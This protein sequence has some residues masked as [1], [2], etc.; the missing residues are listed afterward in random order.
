MSEELRLHEGRSRSLAQ[1]LEE[2]L[3][4]WAERTEI[5]VEI[6]ALPAHDVPPSTAR[7]VLATLGEALANVESHSGA[8]V[9]SVA[10]TLGPSGLRMTVS[11]NGVGFIGPL[12]GR[13][14]TAMRTHFDQVGGTLSIN[15]VLGEG[16]TVSGAV[17]HR[18]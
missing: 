6:W 12:T 1:A 11:D 10:V 16:T 15:G 14:V 17:P 7:A 9:V 8:R 2:H 4:E 5:A 13:G 18:S 3:A